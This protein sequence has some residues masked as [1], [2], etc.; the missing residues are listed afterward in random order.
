MLST[1][2]SPKYT[3]SSIPP[4]SPGTSEAEVGKLR[5]VAWEPFAGFLEPDI[6]AIKELQLYYLKCTFILV[7]SILKAKAVRIY[8]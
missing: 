2:L 8:C 5:K 3:L 6:K 7:C 1:I 4:E